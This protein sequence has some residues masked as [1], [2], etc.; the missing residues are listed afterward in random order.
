[1][2]KLAISLYYIICISTFSFAQIN[3]SID[4]NCLKYNSATVAKTM[5]VLLGEDSI[6]EILYNNFQIVFL[7]QV[8][9]AGHV[10][11][12]EKVNTK[13]THN[14]NFITLIEKQLIANDIQFYICFSKSPSEINET[15]IIKSLRDYYKYNNGKIISF[16]FPGELMNSYEYE[17][18]KASEMGVYLSKFD[19]LLIQ[20]D[21]YIP[22]HSDVMKINK[23]NTCPCGCP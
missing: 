16:S 13:W 23:T 1:M 3:I 19:Y 9:S 15:A 17:N 6:K 5:L 4:D 7:S 10:L 21:K 2:K 14:N 12:I 22:A 11:K 8:D 18:N 20:I